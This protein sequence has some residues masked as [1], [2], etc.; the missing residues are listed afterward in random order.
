[1]LV[2]PEVEVFAALALRPKSLRNDEGNALAPVGATAPTN[3]LLELV[4]AGLRE[5]LDSF[6]G[7]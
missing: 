6:S 5:R 2:P 3:Q 4:A 1:V 7:G